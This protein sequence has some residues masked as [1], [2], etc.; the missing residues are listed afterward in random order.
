M[1]FKIFNKKRKVTAIALSILFLMLLVLWFIKCYSTNTRAFHQNEEYYKIGEYVNLDGDFFFNVNEKTK[2]Y[3]IKVNSY[4]IVNY[5]DF[6][7]S[8]HQE[9]PC[10]DGVSLKNILMVNVTVRNE[11]NTDGCLPFKGFA[12]YN[13]ALQVPIDF[14]ALNLIDP[15]IEGSGVLRLI[16]N[17]QVT[18]TFP[19]SSMPLDETTNS[20]K[21]NYILEN[22][23]LLLCVSEFPVRKLITVHN[24]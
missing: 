20:K 10:Y 14:E 21:L 5:N 3:S 8:Y 17:S 7:N 24:N 4:E 9:I 13:G 12:L 22:E 2:G 16:E 23:P 6:Y 19:F 11:L 18:L 1:T 15:K